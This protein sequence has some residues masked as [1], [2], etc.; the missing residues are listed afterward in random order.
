M[1]ALYKDIHTYIEFENKKVLEVGCQRGE[2]IDTIYP[3]LTTKISGIDINQRYVNFCA[4]K[5]PKLTFWRANIVKGVRSAEHPGYEYFD[6]VV[7]NSVLQY[8]DTSLSAR[9]AIYMM[10]ER[11]TDDGVLFIGD[12]F[13][14]RFKW[15][16]Q[17]L[18][19]NKIKL[20]KMWLG[21]RFSFLYLS[22]AWFHQLPYH[23]TTVTTTYAKKWRY[24]VLI[25]K[26]FE[27][28]GLYHRSVS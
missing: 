5:Y 28:T 2:L 20:A 14:E 27:K 9:G 13:D 6:V 1:D 11:L 23:V 16:Y 21:R 25:R 19:M 22:P 26:N 3:S 15:L 24:H 12:V 18:V 7:C 17:L 8:I 10:V 4:E